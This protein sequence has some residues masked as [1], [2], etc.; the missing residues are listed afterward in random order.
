[1]S[2]TL[3]KLNARAQNVYNN[4]IEN[5]VIN[6][7]P[8]MLAEFTPLELCKLWHEYCVY[9]TDQDG[10]LIGGADYDDEVYDALAEL[11]YFDYV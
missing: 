6:S 11:G 10:A 4:L 3:A 5:R 9:R 2:T 8:K 1:M 7:T